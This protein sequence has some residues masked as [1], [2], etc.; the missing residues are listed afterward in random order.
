MITLISTPISAASVVS[1]DESRAAEISSDI[2]NLWIQSSS[3]L[4]KYLIINRSPDKN[5]AMR[6]WLSRLPCAKA[7]ELASAMVSSCAGAEIPTDH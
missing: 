6:Q 2:Q 1:L 7:R 4:A 3:A 5:N